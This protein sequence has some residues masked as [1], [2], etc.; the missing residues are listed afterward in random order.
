MIGY[1]FNKSAKLIIEFKRYERFGG[2]YDVVIPLQNE[3]FKL[4]ADDLIGKKLQEVIEELQPILDK[5]KNELLP[6]IEQKQKQ[7]RDSFDVDEATRQVFEGRVL[8]DSL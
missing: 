4:I 5:K 1:S 6:I 2:V 7:V 3:D 8:N